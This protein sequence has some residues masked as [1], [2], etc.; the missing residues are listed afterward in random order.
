MKKTILFCGALVFATTGCSTTYKPNPNIVSLSAGM[1]EAEAQQVLYRLMLP[2]DKAGKPVKSTFVA[3]AG[4][5][6]SNPFS[7]DD[8]DGLDLK[9][10]R[11]AVSFN[12]V[13]KGKLLKTESRGTVTS[14][15]GMTMK[16]YFERVPYREHLPFANIKSVK[17]HEPGLLGTACGRKEGQS[18][19][20]IRES[21]TRWYAVLIPTAEKERFIAAWL[22]LH[23]GAKITD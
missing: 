9:V 13:K 10:T 21:L 2:Q 20:A 22:R 15:G 3:Y 4:I 17:I 14:A 16:H 12:A 19:I 8:R 23:P 18:E 1:S 6:N 11:D 7:A 5:C